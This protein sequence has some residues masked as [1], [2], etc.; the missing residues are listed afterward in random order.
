MFGGMLLAIGISF[1]SNVKCANFNDIYQSAHATAYC[2]TGIT[3]SGEQTRDGICAAKREWLG[4][5]IYIYQKLPGGEIGKFI[6]KY[7]CRDTGGTNGLKTGK[8]I[9]IW[10][11]DLE[12]C[13]EFMNLVYEDGCKGRIY[14]RVE[15]PEV[16]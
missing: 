1:C 16:E 11:P 4:K 9:D 5:D 6:G 7:E 13:Q 2:L 12:S 10:R 3:A 15:D 8:V 14:I